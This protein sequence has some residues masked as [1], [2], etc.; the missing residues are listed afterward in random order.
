MSNSNVLGIEAVAYTHACAG[1][2]L[3]Q[4]GSH[5]WTGRCQCCFTTQVSSKPEKCPTTCVLSQAW[6]WN[7]LANPVSEKQDTVMRDGAEECSQMMASLAVTGEASAT[8]V[9][10]FANEA[11]TGVT[12][13]SSYVGSSVSRPQADLQ[14]IKYYFARPR[15]IRRGTFA[16]GSRANQFTWDASGGNL[17][18]AFPQWTNRL[19]GAYGIRFTMCF[20][21]Q[22]A[23]TAFHQ[24][25]A[26]LS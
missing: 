7:R 4:N 25:V 23:V 16:F 14:D 18:L 19:A 13:N 11:C 2:S 15:L 22:V 24:G 10:T 6:V 21:L 5:A 17:L 8:G 3:G 1:K 12:V 20:R 26:A 9:T